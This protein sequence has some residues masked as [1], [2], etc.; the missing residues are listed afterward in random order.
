MKLFALTLSS[1]LLF[2]ALPA[3]AQSPDTGGSSPAS[4]KP[5]DTATSTATDA[6]AQKKKPKKIWTNE[7]IGSVKGDVS[8]VGDGNASPSK[9][10]DKRPSADGAGDAHQQQIQGYRDRIQECQSQIDAID[11]RIAQLRNFKAENTAP[12]G[13][14]NPNQ[15]YNMVPVEDQVKQLEEKRKQ[16][17]TKIDDTEIEARK[18]GVDSADLR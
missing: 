11:K 17:Q 8:V 4:A 3:C 6:A 5:A 18:N 12:S 14:I 7:E 15:G 10:G 13:G 9:G 1:F 2:A 16:L